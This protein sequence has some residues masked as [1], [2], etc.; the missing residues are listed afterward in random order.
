MSEN[1]SVNTT[2]IRAAIS[3]LALGAASWMD[4]SG[5]MTFEKMRKSAENSLR[6]EQVYE[7]STWED[8]VAEGREILGFTTIAALRK[9][10]ETHAVELGK[11]II[12][13]LGGNPYYLSPCTIDTLYEP[14]L[15]RQ[16]E[17]FGVKYRNCN[18]FVKTAELLVTDMGEIIVLFCRNTEKPAY[19]LKNFRRGDDPEKSVRK[20]LRIWRSGLVVAVDAESRD[21][22]RRYKSGCETDPFWRREGATTG[23]VQELLGVID[24]VEIQAGSSDGELF[25]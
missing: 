24:K 20:I 1:K 7:P 3:E 14:K 16:G 13:P 9:P 23:E 25:D 21:E 11:N 22:I 15:I 19:C 18:C 10:E 4:S 17:V 2:N 8:A 12:Y 6:V 5:L